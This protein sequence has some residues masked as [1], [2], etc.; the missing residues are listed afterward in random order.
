MVTLDRIR[1][2]GL[3]KEKP[4]DFEGF[5]PF[6]RGLWD[7]LALAACI[8]GASRDPEKASDQSPGTNSSSV[9]AAWLSENR[10]RFGVYRGSSERRLLN[11]ELAK[12]APD[13]PP[14]HALR[15]ATGRN[16]RQRF[17]LL[18]GF[19]ALRIC[20][21]LPLPATTGLHVGP[22]L[23][24]LVWRRSP[25]AAM[26]ALATRASI[27]RPTGVRPRCRGVACSGHLGT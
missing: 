16:R 4:L 20:D 8:T 17:C 9:S 14:D 3:L 15:S 23:C 25:S 12:A 18:G 22:F 7:S 2:T 24:C 26:P 5:F 19:S 1:L 21:P 11:E 27:G 6:W 10:G 13:R